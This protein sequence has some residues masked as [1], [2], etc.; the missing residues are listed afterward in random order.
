MEPLCHGRNHGCVGV[1]NGPF[2]RLGR[3]AGPL[4]ED[5]GG[6]RQKISKARPDLGC[7]ANGTDLF[8]LLLDGP[9][10]ER[11]VSNANERG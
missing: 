8:V 9:R 1:S 5:L 4:A 7:R 6:S 2:A 11:S 3:R 10:T